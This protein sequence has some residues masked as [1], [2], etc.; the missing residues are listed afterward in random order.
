MRQTKLELLN[1]F[2]L[3]VEKYKPQRITQYL[4]TL[5]FALTK[6]IISVHYHFKGM[7]RSRTNKFLN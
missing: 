4:N 6:V 7:H 1:V 2:N 3:F 5:F